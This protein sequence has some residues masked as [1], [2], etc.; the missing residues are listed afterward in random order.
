MA[1]E[2]QAVV[3]GS[4]ARAV[5]GGFRI[6]MYH[7][8]ALFGLAAAV[9]LGVGIIIWSMRPNYV[10]VFSRQ[11]DM[12]AVEIAEV[13]RGENIAF[14]IDANSGLVLVPEKE[15][16]R[17]RMALTA[18]GMPYS[19]NSGY[20]SLRQEQSLGTSQF[21]ETAR[22]HHSLE[23]ELA[24][25]IS[26]MGNVESARVH[27][28][29]PKQSVFVRKQAKPSASV[30][31]R[32]RPGRS[33]DPGQVSSI[34][35]LVASSVPYME[36]GSVTV[37]DQWG[38]ML[39]SQESDPEMVETRRQLEY[40]RKLEGDYI[41]RIETLLTPIVGYGKVKAQVNVD[42][43]FSSNESFQ[44]LYAQDPAKVRSE[45]VQE[46]Q[47]RGG[48]GTE[49]IPGALSNQP[50][51]AGTLAGETGTETAATEPTRTSRSSTRNY[52]L[53]KTIRRVRQGKGDV[54]RLT[55]A[56]VIDNK[57]GSS[58]R[59]K[60]TPYKT[61]ELARFTEL[62]KKAV[63]FDEARG[64]SVEVV[65]SPF[66]APETVEAPPEEPFWSKPWI[67]TVLKQVAGAAIVL[68]M[69]FGI[70]RPALRSLASR[71]ESKDGE[72][73]DNYQSQLTLASPAAYG[74]MPGP[75]QIYGDILNM[76]RVMA[77]EDP[78]RVAK[79]IKDWV[80]EDGQ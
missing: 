39:S 72:G 73:S 63:G 8:K 4:L 44:E 12:D 69:I 61:E 27:L 76:A 68:F 30:M 7:I 64:D 9:S 26:G 43:D 19:A 45:Q 37:V 47:S 2:N 11:S 66:Q 49:G 23:T 14:Q 18:S 31:L 51:E 3:P 22:Y 78:K 55:V 67:W 1:T 36:A 56:V 21:M 16:S 57:A 17:A 5:P 59:S 13:L 53:D 42:V 65:N 46:S 60:G 28:A 70:V 25:T 35:Y 34:V 75:P 58:A 20:E 62:V 74:S 52:E 38:R 29:L 33:L 50:P 6:S 15:I 40:V 24:R 77:E 54:S 32:L 80:S 41:E 79:V 48:P 71:A 10:P